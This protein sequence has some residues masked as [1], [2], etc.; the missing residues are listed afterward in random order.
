[1]LLVANEMTENTGID[2]VDELGKGKS[3]TGKRILREIESM[4]T[5]EHNYFGKYHHI[6]YIKMALNQTDPRS[7]IP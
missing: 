3:A 4:S 6:I 2:L 5:P 7:A 1:M